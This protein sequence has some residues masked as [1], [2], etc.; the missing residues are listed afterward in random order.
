MSCINISDP[1]SLVPCAAKTDIGSL[2]C[3]S[4]G[5]TSPAKHAK[6]VM[7]QIEAIP[8]SAAPLC[9]DTSAIKNVA[10]AKRPAL[11]EE[12]IMSIMSW[13]K[14]G[15]MKSLVI[16]LLVRCPAL[17]RSYESTHVLIN[18]DIQEI[19][20]PAFS[21]CKLKEANSLNEDGTSQELDSF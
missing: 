8:D 2:I 13:E 7:Q 4:P 20:V 15:L 5:R 1:N 9:V 17:T 19:N 14:K 12:E 21:L 3:A 18:S 10:A 11:P 6:R 16:A